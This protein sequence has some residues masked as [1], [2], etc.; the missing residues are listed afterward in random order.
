MTQPFGNDDDKYAADKPEDDI[1]NR[2]FLPP[3]M[4]MLI[5]EYKTQEAGEKNGTD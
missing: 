3:E 5:G 2:D 1:K 4:W